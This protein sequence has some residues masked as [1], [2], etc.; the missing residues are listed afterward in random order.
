MNDVGLRPII[1]SYAITIQ[2]TPHPSVVTNSGDL[3]SGAEANLRP[4]LAW[5][6]CKYNKYITYDF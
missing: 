1:E 4:T 2:T 3:Y 5:A 6:L